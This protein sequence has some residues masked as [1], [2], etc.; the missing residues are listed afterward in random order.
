[1]CLQMIPFCLPRHVFVRCAVKADSTLTRRGLHDVNIQ[2]LLCVQLCVD[3]VC[4]LSKIMWRVVCRAKPTEQL[5][6]MCIRIAFWTC[7][8]RTKPQSAFHTRCDRVRRRGV[9]S[10]YRAH[11]MTVSDT[12]CCRNVLCRSICHRPTPCVQT[13]ESGPL[14]AARSVARWSSG[15]HTNALMIVCALCEGRQCLID[16]ERRLCI[17]ICLKIHLVCMSALRCFRKFICY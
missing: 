1:M 3:F 12:V 6:S 16:T 8:R 15:S 5:P 11:E 10:L 14:P 9:D 4:V 2:H 13:G 17:C 7:I